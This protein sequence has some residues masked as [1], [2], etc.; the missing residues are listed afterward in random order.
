MGKK[1]FIGLMLSALYVH[2]AEPD[3]KF[4]TCIV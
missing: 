3:K 2:P 4:R 1:Y